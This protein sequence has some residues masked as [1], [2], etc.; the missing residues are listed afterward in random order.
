MKIAIFGDSFGDDHINWIDR[1]DWLDVGPSWIDYLRQFHDIDNFCEGGSSLY[2][3]KMI[4]DK[5]DLSKYDKVIFIVTSPH[6]RT[7][8]NSNWN[9]GR[10]E[11]MLSKKNLDLEWKTKLLALRSYFL[12][13]W[14]E[15][16]QYFHNLM[17]KDIS[18]ILPSILHLSY[19]QLD[20]V[21]NWECKKL[22]GGLI[23]HDI[24]QAGYSDARKCHMCEENNL[25]LGK[26]IQHCLEN[27]LELI[28]DIEKFVTPPREFDHYFRKIT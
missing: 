15:S 24:F 21:S 28:I 12:H 11:I 3:S 23:L 7:N 13:V 1:N 19:K 25:I 8:Y 20:E 27:N 17:I 18:N 6:R 16:D 4:F 26:Q 2:Y 10:L 9:L 14:N 5:T 22:Y